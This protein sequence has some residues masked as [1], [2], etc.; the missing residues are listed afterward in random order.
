MKQKIRFAAK[1]SASLVAVSFALPT[2]LAFA[3]EEAEG[4]AVGIGLLIPKLGEF[5]PMLIGFIVLWAVLAKFAWPAFIGM[6]D[7]RAAKIKESLEKSEE[8]RQ[9]SERLLEEHKA[10]LTQ[11]KKE[12]SE[13]IAAAKQSAECVKAEITASAQNEAEIIIAKAR[14][15]I[16]NEKKV[17]I[18]ELQAT[19]ADM[20]ISVARKVIGTDLSTAEHKRIIERYIAEAGSFNEN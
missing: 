6:I 5:I 2:T 4:G 1:L 18:A 11:A 9:E 13:I 14:H 8:A 15:A 12:A 16:E 19:A 3:A 10:A 7:K 20:T 17:A